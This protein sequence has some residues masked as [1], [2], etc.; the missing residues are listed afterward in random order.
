MYLFYKSLLTVASKFHT[1]AMDNA[2]NCDTTVVHLS[3]LIEGFRGQ[4]SRI[5]CFPH[6][7]NLI[8]KVYTYA[9]HSH[10]P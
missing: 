1:I 10:S 9:I 8:A 5:R 2:A 7:V 3:T 6:T 4:Q